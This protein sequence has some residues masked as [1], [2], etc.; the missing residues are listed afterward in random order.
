[1]RRL[2][3]LVL[4]AAVLPLLGWWT[5]GLFD[6]DEG[7]YAA[8]A[9]EMN[10]RGEWVTPYFNGQP[11]FEKPILLYWIAKPSLL[12]FGDM[13]GPRVPSILATV[14][15]I[16]LLV[17]FARRRFSESVAMWA[18][19]AYGT[20]L[21]VFAAGRMMLTDPL[22]VLCTTGMFL[23]FWE[24][25]VGD[26]RY[27]LATAAFLGLAVLAKGPVAGLLFVIV[28]A[29][30]MWRLTRISKFETRN[31]KGFWLA[32]TVVFAAVVAAWYVPAYLANGQTFVQKFLIEQN[33]G[34]FTGGDQAHTL[35]FFP[36]VFFYL[37]ILLLGTAPWI[38]WALPALF[39]PT[40]PGWE[41]ER[42]YL[43]IWFAT[44]FVFFTVSGAKLPHYI[45]PALPPFALLAALRLPEM[46]PRRLA[47]AGAWALA[48][49][50]FAQWGFTGYYCG[51]TVFGQ[52]LPGFHAEVHRLAKY[53][54]EQ[55][56][57]GDSVAEFQMSRRE[58]ELG[59]GKPKIQETS[60]PSTLL[61]LNRTVTDTDDW[62]EI[63]K[64]P[65]PVWIITRWN[66]PVPPDVPRVETPFKQDLYALYRMP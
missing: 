53:V 46:N 38:G 16:L 8:I 55:A 13:V 24:S 42:R 29:L 7:F 60:H 64:L 12:L 51:T 18:A 66:R 62:K 39:R 5:Y 14:G 48:M 63:A 35:P 25:L 15:T 10:R 11:W 57:P 44:I 40:K 9:A 6:L 31:F 65:R 27:R 61:Y 56:A 4:L 21:L 26:R 33:V 52:A 3:P 17:W 20:S 32:G 54:R 43:V 50:A 45:L 34:R 22:L 36:G 30:T 1:M 37:P 23:T 58:Q 49:W 41:A 47:F 2:W 59:T 28:V 19:I